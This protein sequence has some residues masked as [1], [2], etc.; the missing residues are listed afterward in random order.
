M[1]TPHTHD[2]ATQAQIVLGIGK[3]PILIFLESEYG[4]A[5]KYARKE[6]L[7]IAFDFRSYASVS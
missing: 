4:Y 1:M 5:K 6:G 2:I 7:F 3:D